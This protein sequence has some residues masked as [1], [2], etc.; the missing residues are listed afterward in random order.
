MAQ[1]EVALRRG[2]DASAIVEA[3]TVAGNVAILR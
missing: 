3:D 1:V 2:A